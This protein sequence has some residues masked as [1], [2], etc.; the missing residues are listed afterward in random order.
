MDTSYWRVA[1]LLSHWQFFFI[2]KKI[3]QNNVKHKFI[4]SKSENSGSNAK[5]WQL[6]MELQ[7]KQ[8][9]KPRGRS[10]V[11]SESWPP[12]APMSSREGSRLSVWTHIYALCVLD[13]HPN[14]TTKFCSKS[15]WRN[16][17]LL[18]RPSFPPPCHGSQAPEL[19][20]H[21]SV[22]PRCEPNQGKLCQL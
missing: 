12:G 19:H 14:L 7:C 18:S 15:S 6:H 21:S 8:R 10:I 5:N 3:N 22:G 2:Q 16:S 17:R 11:L 9:Q 4:V 1:K 13:W 20:W